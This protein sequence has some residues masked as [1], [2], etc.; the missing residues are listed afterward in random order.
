M[1]SCRVRG[2]SVASIFFPRG[3]G[4]PSVFCKRQA[5]AAPQASAFKVKAGRAADPPKAL[6]DQGYAESAAR[7][8]LDGGPTTLRPLQMDYRLRADR[9]PLDINAT[10]GRRQGSIFASVR[11]QFMQH[12]SQGDRRLGCEESPRA[13]NRNPLAIAVHGQLV[14]HKVGNV[15]ALPTALCQRSMSA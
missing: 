10:I 11:S 1:A 4:S 2:P 12:E 7:G 5:N 14:A 3:S 15:G 8:H 6:L 9:G 13:N